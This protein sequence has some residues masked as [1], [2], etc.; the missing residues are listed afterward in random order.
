MEIGTPE[1]V[2]TREGLE[3]AYGVPAAMLKD[4]EQ[5]DRRRLEEEADLL[6]G[7]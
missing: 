7:R 1:E 2:L 3:A 4:K 5:L 6:K